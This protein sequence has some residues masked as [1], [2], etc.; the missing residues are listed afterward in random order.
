MSTGGEM[1]GPEA[2]EMAV[3]RGAAGLHVPVGWNA[4]ALLFALAR[5]ETTSWERMRASKHENVYCYGGRYHSAKLKPEEWLYGCAVHCSYSPWQIM[6]PTAYLHG[7]RG[8]PVA[9][10]SPLVA[11]DYVVAE[12][13]RKVFDK[14]I[15]E[16]IEDVAD[17]WN[18]GTAR[19]GIEPIPYKKAV[20]AHYA[21]F[22]GG[23]PPPA[24]VTA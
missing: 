16:T 23:P 6:Y 22:A 24:T 7:F 15:D 2:I 19:D 3:T 5:Q 20:A 9:L 4:R 12:L 8:D 13:N 17:A 1:Y 10:R 11:I 21:A 14:F 18:S